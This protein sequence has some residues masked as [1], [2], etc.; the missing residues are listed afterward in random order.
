MD[1]QGQTGITAADEEFLAAFEA[2]KIANQDFHHRDHLRLA[3]IQIHRL[4]VD[5]AADTVAGAIRRFAAHHGHGNRY[6]ETMTRFWVRV[7][8]MGITRHPTLSFDDLLAAE[9]HLLDKNLPYRHWSRELMASDEA[10][11]QWT[12]PD[13]R[14]MPAS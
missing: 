4:G 7:V 1:S 9:P 8:G 12:E 5:R 14:L 6:H 2:G 3:W 13:V 11:R 10:R